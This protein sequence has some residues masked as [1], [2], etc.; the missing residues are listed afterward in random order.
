VNRR[1]FW[2]QALALVVVALL[3]VVA[4]GVRG[5]TL[6]CAHDG[7]EVLKPYAVVIE[8][9]DGSAENF[10]GVACADRWMMRSGRL[11]R[12]VW[13]TDCVA[14]NRVRAHSAAYVRTR[15]GWSEGV[16]DPIRVFASREQAITHVREFGGE[17]LAGPRRP[18]QS[19]EIDES[20][21]PARAE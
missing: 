16:P 9:D 3:P 4:D 15:L 7:A 5:R 20:E 18:L 21:R 17:L 8:L 1:G 2:L 13:V 12:A 10:C 14:G 6:R 11:P 19:G